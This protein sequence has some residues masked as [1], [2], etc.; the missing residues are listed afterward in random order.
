MNM[1]NQELKEL[2]A[3][4]RR[5][6]LAETESQTIVDGEVVKKSGRVTSFYDFETKKYRVWPKSGFVKSFTTKGRRL[7]NVISNPSDYMRMH[8]ITEC[9]DDSNMI[10]YKSDDRKIGMPATRKLMQRMTE[11]GEDSCNRFLSRMKIK[12]L[13]KEYRMTGEDSQSESHLYVN[14]VYTMKDTGISLNLYKLFKTEVDPFLTDFAKRDFEFM[15]YLEGNEE[16]LVLAEELERKELQEQSQKEQIIEKTI[17][18]K[19]LSRLH[20]LNDV[21]GCIYVGPNDLS[22]SKYEELEEALCKCLSCY[23]SDPEVQGLIERFE[24]LIEP[25]P[26]TVRKNIIKSEEEVYNG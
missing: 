8:I 1:S 13:I 16:L 14:P 12:G 19:E 9:I 6:G 22:M 5:I 10:I 11:L 23:S 26:N 7:K 25:D 20:H 4:A 24:G 21:S 15:M 18:S 3:K 17:G 2:L